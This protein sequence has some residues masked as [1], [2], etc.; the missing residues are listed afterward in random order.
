MGQIKRGGRQVWTHAGQSAQ[1]SRAYWDTSGG[2]VGTSW[3]QVCHR[4]RK[5]SR[6]CGRSQGCAERIQGVAKDNWEKSAKWCGQRMQSR[7]RWE[8]SERQVRNHAG[9]STQSIQSVLGDKWGDK[10]EIMG[11]EN[12]ECSGRQL[13][14]SLETSAKSCGPKQSENPECL[15]QENKPGDKRQIMRPEH[16]PLSKEY[17]PLT[18]KPVWGKMS[19]TNVAFFNRALPFCPSPSKGKAS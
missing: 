5:E 15:L 1:A 6:A 4:A 13:G 10:P 7:G 12:P 8:T 17:E 18:G 19:K 16:A 2:K 9:Q 14:D 3:S 11:A